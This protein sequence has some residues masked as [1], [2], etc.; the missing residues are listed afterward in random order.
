M[1][2]FDGIR[3]SLGPF[4]GVLSNPV[5]IFIGLVWA[6]CFIWAAIALVTNIAGFARARRAGRSHQADE[7]LSG[8]AWAGGAIVLLGAVPVIFGIL[9]RMAA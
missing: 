4:A 5:G 8:L 9:S 6:G 2:P 1:N 3:P 7:S